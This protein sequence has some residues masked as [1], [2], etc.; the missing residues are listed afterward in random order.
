M[1]ELS[2]QVECARCK[3]LYPAHL[4]SGTDVLCVYCNADEQNSLPVAKEQ[5]KPEL[6]PEEFSA[7]D[8]AREELAMRFCIRK[9]LLPFVE[10]FNAD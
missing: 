10:R 9:R 5:P 6:T 7:K 8:K 2:Q 4:Y 3:N 1:S